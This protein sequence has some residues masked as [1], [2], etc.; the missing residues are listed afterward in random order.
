M[1][2]RTL[3]EKVEKC[4][5]MP[6]SGIDQWRE[7]I[8]DGDIMTNNAEGYISQLAEL[9]SKL[10]CSTDKMNIDLVDLFGNATTS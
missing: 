6:V 10:F 5:D 1:M 4:L 8:T 3:D 2:A 7:Y 9:R